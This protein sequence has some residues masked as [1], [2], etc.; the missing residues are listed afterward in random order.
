MK[1]ISIW[2]D[3]V[4]REFLSTGFAALIKNG[5]INGA[6]SN[7]AIFKNA[8]CS[9]KAYDADKARLSSCEPLEIYE[10]LATLDIKLAAEALLP[11]FANGEDGFVSLE[12]NPEL[13]DD[14]KATFKE[15]KRLHATIKMPNVMIKVPATKAGYKAMSKLMACGISVNATLVFST[16]QT[17][18]CLEAFAKG[19]RKFA[20]RFGG[21]MLPKGVISVFVSRFDRALNARLAAANIEQN[22]FGIYNATKCYKLVEESALPNVRV[23]FAST[24]VKG[25]E[26]KK[27]YYIDELLFKRIVNTAPLDAIE[28]FAAT[29]HKE[30][31]PASEEVLNKFFVS[32]V[33]AGV[34]Y[35]TVCETL[36]K[37]GLEAFKQAFGEILQNVKKSA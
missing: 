10:S 1:N 18:K 5:T 11:K 2:C 36:L 4:E 23:L 33:N 31:T 29:K 6:T 37:E 14:A 20:E 28:A 12:V 26:L 19:T 24:G 32:C 25:D 17:Q 7:P 34:D 3:F 21:C 27:D 8:F 16:K 35:E 30:K 22:K 13:C 9:S 15:G